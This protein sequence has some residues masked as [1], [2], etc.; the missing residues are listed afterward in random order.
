MLCL[1]ENTEN[2]FKML[3]YTVIF[4]LKAYGHQQHKNQLFFNGD[5][6]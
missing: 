3:N 5:V 2:S 4:N 6:Q 1:S